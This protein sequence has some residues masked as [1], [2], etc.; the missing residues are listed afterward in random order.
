MQN[1]CVRG[2]R[3]AILALALT[4]QAFPQCADPLVTV[5]SGSYA[6]TTG[7]CYYS[8][9]LLYC[10]GSFACGTHYTICE[11]ASGSSGT[12]YSYNSC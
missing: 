11:D 6:T 8:E 3:T 5:S 1:G 2:A 7:I 10:S 4:P 9:A 12:V